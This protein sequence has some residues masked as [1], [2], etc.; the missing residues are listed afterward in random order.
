MDDRFRLLTAPIRSANITGRI[1]WQNV[2]FGLFLRR[3]GIR[4]MK[5]AENRGGRL[6]VSRY[7]RDRI[8]KEYLS[9][10]REGF[11][12]SGKAAL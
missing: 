8:A 12:G 10:I 5:T 11:F 6:D 3:R 2:F 7:D 1:L 9:C 4:K